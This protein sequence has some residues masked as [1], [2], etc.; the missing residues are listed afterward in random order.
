MPG[1][2]PFLWLSESGPPT[3]FQRLP[4]GGMCVSAFLFVRLGGK[5][6]LGKYADDPRWEELAGLNHEWRRMHADR[7]TLPARQMRFGEDPREA[8]RH[9]GETILQVP[10]MAYSEPRPEVDLYES[11]RS[12]GQQHYDVWFLFDAAMPKGIEAARPPWYADLAWKD[13]TTLVPAEYARG[14]EDVVARWRAKRPA[15]A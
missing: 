7:W 9:I 11:R 4:R 6:L 2:G 14:H 10:G 13:P 15:K 8:A 3:G 1:E 5:I 12:P